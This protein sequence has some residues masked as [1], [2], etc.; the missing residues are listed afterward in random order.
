MWGL[1]A[2]CL[3]QT[4]FNPRL[5]RAGTK[6]IKISLK[7]LEENNFGLKSDQAEENLSSSLFSYLFKQSLK[8]S[9]CIEF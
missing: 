9:R 5:I 1:D 2:W 6:K 7:A 3:P 8:V 4:L